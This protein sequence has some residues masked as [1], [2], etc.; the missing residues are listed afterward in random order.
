MLGVS[1]SSLQVTCSS[2]V[3]HSIGFRGHWFD[4]LRIFVPLSRRRN[5]KSF[6]KVETL[7]ILPESNFTVE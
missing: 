2:M 7:E 3:D 4:P 5:V 1:P 6:T